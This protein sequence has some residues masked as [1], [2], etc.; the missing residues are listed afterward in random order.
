M[1]FLSA[2]PDISRIFHYCEEVALYFLKIGSFKDVFSRQEFSFSESVPYLALS[3][4]KR[5]EFG[6]LTYVAQGDISDVEFTTI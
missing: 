4:S 3:R 1:N 6:T 2:F 5:I